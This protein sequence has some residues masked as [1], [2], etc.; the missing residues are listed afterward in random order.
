MMVILIN[1]AVMFVPVIFTRVNNTTPLLGR[2]GFFDEF[3]IA[4]N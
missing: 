4:F 1:D 2:Q 3:I